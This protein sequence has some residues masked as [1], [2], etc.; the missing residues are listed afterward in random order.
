MA[1]REGTIRGVNIP[2]GSMILAGIASANRD[3]ERFARPDE[4]DIDR[5]DADIL[6]FGFG[7]KFCPGTHMAKQQL[8]AAL[9]VLL[10]RLP[11]LRLADDD[12]GAV[13]S[14][15]NLRSVSSLRCKW[16]T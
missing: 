14:G 6:T 15:C 7:V 10:D 5:P 11:G 3:P 13:P 2:A 8:L 16:D 4:F 1:L 12:S 9:E